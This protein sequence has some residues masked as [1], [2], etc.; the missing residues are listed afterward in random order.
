M[1]ARQEFQEASRVENI[2]AAHCTR[3]QSDPALS[4]VNVGSP[5]TRDLHDGEWNSTWHAASNN[6]KNTGEKQ[7]CVESQ[8]SSNDVGRQAPKCRPDKQP[9][10]RCQR[11]TLQ[12]GVWVAVLCQNCRLGDGLADDQE[13]CGRTS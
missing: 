8:S 4:S 13:L 10:L 1:S 5:G 7:R 12:V 11:N 2:I 3:V 9:N 6:N